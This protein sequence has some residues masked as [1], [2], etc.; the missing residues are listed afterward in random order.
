MWQLTED[1]SVINEQIRA[2][3]V[4]PEQ[5]SLIIARNVITRS[6]GFE[7]EVLCDIV[8]REV[9]SGEI[10]LI[11]SDG[12]HSMVDDRTIANIIKQG[13]AQDLVQDLVDE[14]KKNGG[15]DNVT[16]LILQVV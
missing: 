5:A 13:N 15:D 3:K 12:L 10:Y 2:G 11:C 16:T 9:Q 7:R 1:H 8:Q 4:K 6:V 14:A